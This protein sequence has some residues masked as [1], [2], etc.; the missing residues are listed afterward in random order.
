MSIDFLRKFRALVFRFNNLITTLRIYI[1]AAGNGSISI[2]E[3]CRFGAAFI[4]NVTDGGK[5]FIGRNTY[6]GPNVQI[7]VQGGTLIIEN[8]VFIGVG[9]IIACRDNIYIGSDA[10]IAEYVVIRDQD[11][12]A[13]SRPVRCSGFHTLPIRIGQDVWIGCKASIL[14]GAS[15]GDRCVVGAHALVRSHI[16]GDM[17]AVGVPARVVKRVGG[18]R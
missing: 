12:K 9:S 11:H 2:G 3:G 14:R 1:F 4:L 5:V 17:L 16:P 6:I 15:V 18:S 7:I 13:D 8:N 10:L